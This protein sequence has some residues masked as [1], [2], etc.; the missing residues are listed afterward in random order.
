MCLTSFVYVAELLTL[1]N[2]FCSFRIFVPSEYVGALIG[3]KGQTIR[4]ITTASKVTR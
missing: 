2:P 1:S 3:K 4:N